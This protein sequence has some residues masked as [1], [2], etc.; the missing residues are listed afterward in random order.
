MTAVRTAETPEEKLDR[1]GGERNPVKPTR[2][3]ELYRRSRVRLEA[4]YSPHYVSGPGSYVWGRFASEVNFSYRSKA[5]SMDLA[6][7]SCSSRTR[8]ATEL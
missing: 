6:E 1:F 7:A 2:A 8:S 5:C 4:G 3:L